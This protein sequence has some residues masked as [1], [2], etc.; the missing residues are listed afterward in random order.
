[1]SLLQSELERCKYELGYN[2]I[3]LSNPYIDVVTVFEGVIQTYLSSGASTTSVTPVTAADEPT[4]VTLTLASGTG[5]STGARV[6]VDVDGRQE[7]ATA[8]LVSGASLT[9]DLQLAHTGT[10][11]VTVEGGE[12]IVR[13]ILGRIRDCKNEMGSTFGEGSLKK[14]DEVEFY[15]TGDS[16][17]GM[18]GKQLSFWR[19][20]LASALGIPSRWAQRRAGSQRMSVY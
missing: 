5:F 7:I 11:G 19:E 6:V 3:S 1:M 12:S 20:E 8:R 14:V 17:F 10:Y 18:I 2:L 9:L 16:T 15:Q 13:E 4:P